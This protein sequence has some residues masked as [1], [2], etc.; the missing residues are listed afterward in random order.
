M[1]RAQ[2][3]I[4]LRAVTRGGIS[5]GELPHVIQKTAGTENPPAVPRPTLLPLVGKH[6]VSADGVG[7]VLGDQLA[8]LDHVAAR[9]GHALYF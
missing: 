7:P 8:G 2:D 9:F 1:H 5:R 3:G 6:E 4:V